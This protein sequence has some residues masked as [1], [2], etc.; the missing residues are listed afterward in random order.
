[1]FTLLKANGQM[2]KKIIEMIKQL[3]DVSRRMRD[4]KMKYQSVRNK[5]ESQ[6]PRKLYKAVKGDLVDELFAD[7]INRLNCPVQIK[8]LGNN[9]YTFGTKKIF[10]K[11]INGKLVIRVGG[12][13]MGI[14]EF[15]M[16]YGQ[17]ELQKIQKEE[18]KNHIV[19]EEDVGYGDMNIGGG[20]LGDNF[21]TDDDETSGGRKST[22][23]ADAV[24][25]D[26]L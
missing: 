4:Q 23:G 22:L 21:L 11:I 1:M 8:R 3:K 26:Q 14:E 15:M 9:Y 2:K 18:L 5:L 7:Y 24:D 10:A 20:L 16:Y 25:I 6:A 13:Y 17:Q 12:G 19:T